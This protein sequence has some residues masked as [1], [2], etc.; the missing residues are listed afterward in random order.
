[1]ADGRRSLS[2]PYT[3]LREEADLFEGLYHSAR[4]DLNRL[5]RAAKH[6]AN[7]PCPATLSYLSD[8]AVRVQR[9]F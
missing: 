9:P 6:A 5:V 2:H 3:R 7:N 4:E 1:M 8:M